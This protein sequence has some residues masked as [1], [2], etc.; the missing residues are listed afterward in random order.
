ML[1]AI[2]FK[3]TSDKT[4]VASIAEEKATGGSASGSA[5]ITAVVSGNESVACSGTVSVTNFAALGDGEARVI[6]GSTANGSPVEGATVWLATTSTT[7]MATTQADGSAV[8]SGVSEDIVHVTAHKSGWQ[9][10]SVLNPGT[11]DV[12][13]LA[14]K[15]PDRTQAGGFRGS[16]DLSATKRADIKL[17]IAGP[18]LPLNVLDLELESLLGDSIETVINAPDLGLTD[19]KVDLP[20]GIMLALGTQTSPT[21]LEAAIYVAKVMLLQRAA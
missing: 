9:S 7:Q 21:I 16:V 1:G 6:L 18:S 17:G 5:S 19:E 4:D 8:F 20:G 2:E 12:F 14:N 13:V 15:K 3:W 11:K 10:V